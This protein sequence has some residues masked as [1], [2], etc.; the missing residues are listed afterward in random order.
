MGK[1][2]ILPS[3]RDLEEGEHLGE[4]VRKAET[5]DAQP[6]LVAGDVHGHVRLMIVALDVDAGAVRHEVHVGVIHDSG[7]IHGVH[8]GTVPL[9]NAKNHWKLPPVT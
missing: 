7:C 1:E 6:V 3:R 5:E 4:I 8:V 2:R 9:V